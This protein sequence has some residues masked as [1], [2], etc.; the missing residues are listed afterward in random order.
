MLV[1]EQG[2]YLEPEDVKKYL[3]DYRI[4]EEERNLPVPL[5]GRSVEQA[6]RELIFRALM[7]IKGNLVE[8]KNLLT[9][10]QPD[11]SRGDH[12]VREPEENRTLSL[13]DMEQRMIT[14]ALE[15]YKGNRRV[16]ARALN[17]SE[18]T[19]YRKI[20]EFGLE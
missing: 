6:E 1:L 16:A 4:P 20:K 8:L 12:A 2:K 17:I 18:R 11:G 13:Q 10:Q 19:L 15:R 9:R 7:D 3:K 14:E 5:V